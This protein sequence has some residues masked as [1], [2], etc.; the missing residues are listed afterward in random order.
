MFKQRMSVSRRAGGTPCRRRPATAVVAEGLEGRR[1]LSLVP[2]GGEFRANVTT[3][4]SQVFSAV[5]ADADGDYVVAWKSEGQDG[6]AGGIYARRFNPAGQALG[7]EFRVNTTTAGDQ[8]YPAVAMAD[9]GAFVVAW[10]VYSGGGIY[11]RRYDAAGNPVGDEFRV[12]TSAFGSGR[13][14]AIGMN[15]DG[16]FAI[17]WLGVGGNAADRGSFLRRY[18]SGGSPLTASAERVNSTDD[19]S[20]TGTSV[21]VDD[22]GDVVVVWTQAVRTQSGGTSVAAP[23][24]RRYDAATGTFGPIVQVISGSNER[25]G[26]TLRVR[27]DG[28]FVAAWT[29]NGGDGSGPGI[30]L[31]RFDAAGNRIGGEERVNTTTA[32]SQRNPA[33]AMDAA[34][35]YAVVWD[36]PGDF[37]G[38][39]HDIFLQAYRAN[40]SRFGGEARVNLTTAEHQYVPAATMSGDDGQ[41]VVTWHSQNQDEAGGFGVYGRRHAPFGAPSGAA[42][43]LVFDDTDADGVRQTGEPGLVGAIVYVDADNDGSRDPDELFTTT[44]A[45]SN[46]AYR[47]ILATGRHTLRVELPASYGTTAP[48]GGARVVDVA[49]DSEVFAQDFG[50]ASTAV[51]G[52]VYHDLDGD[53]VHDPGGFAPNSGEPGV[54]GRTVWVDLDRDAVR[55]VGDE[56]TVTTDQFGRFSFS[57]AP[58]TYQVREVLPAGWVQTSPAGGG[59]LTF[60][61]AA[62]S[63]TAPRSFGTAQVGRIS[64]FIYDDANG[65]G[66]R[67]GNE[68]VLVPNRTAFID[69]NNDGQLDPGERRMTTQVDGFWFDNLAPGTYVVRQIVPRGWRQTQPTDDQPHVVTVVSGGSPHLYLGAAPASA[70]TIAGRHVFY[71]RSAFDGNA[72]TPADDPRDDDAV[73]LDK[74][75]LRPG[76]A[77]TAANSTSYSRGINGVMVDVANLPLNRTL[78][79]DDF[80]LRVGT[81]GDPANWA[82]APDPSV[83][84][85]RGAGVNGSDRVILTWPDNRILNTW[86]QVTVNANTDT[87][88]AAADDFYFGNLVGDADGSG[89]VNLGDF[90]A[91]RQDFGRTNLSV[92]G[93]RSDFNRDGTVNLA[94]F[95]LLRGNFGRSLPPV[96]TA[97]AG[98]AEVTAAGAVGEPAAERERI[99]A[100]R[101]TADLASPG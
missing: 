89:T 6:D 73:A 65:N 85:R 19:L 77:P 95:G 25:S 87:A 8:A 17:S 40:G 33:L 28:S 61:V 80:T 64:G 56:P 79:A 27:G 36:G 55:D 68:N 63:G 76:Q 24:V 34:G 38:T 54:A 78:T 98:W 3:A 4:G 96:S 46:G 1:L 57:L 18:D 37:N 48:P 66:A 35:N 31:H 71:N 47:L 101:P 97:A 81:G 5:D 72:A 88:L 14:P 30:S 90:G 70:A 10:E 74:R 45:Q 86:L 39:Q 22:T 12:T 75:A 92:T 44:T 58:G 100:G 59:P 69:D 13:L 26:P 42:S 32:G 93:G 60:T 29:V 94:D 21:G 52:F 43:G 83:A 49:A 82:A 9:D 62:G 15:A 51:R 67:D 20:V 7:G 23:H 84:V 50:A 2:V 41:L 99:T 11:A 91:L 16:A 53:G